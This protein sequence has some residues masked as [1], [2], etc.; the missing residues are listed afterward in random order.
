MIQIIHFNLK[1]NVEYKVWQNYF[2]G[3]RGKKCFGNIGWEAVS[4]AHSIAFPFFKLN[5]PVSLI[6]MH[7]MKFI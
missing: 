5:I 2:R 7:A 1:W 6:P 4:G 3:T